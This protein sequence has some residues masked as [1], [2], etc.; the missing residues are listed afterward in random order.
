MSAAASN[1]RPF[2]L[3][4]AVQAAYT[5]NEPRPFVFT[6]HGAEHTA[7]PAASWPLEAQALIAAGQVEQAMRQILGADTYGALIAAGMTMGELTVLLEAIGAE[8]GVA[9]LGN[10]SAPALPATTPT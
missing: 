4:A 6:Y 2:D 9:G 8:S 7:P 3:D 1:G 5:E 10:S